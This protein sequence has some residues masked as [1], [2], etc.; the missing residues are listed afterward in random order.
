MNRLKERTLRELRDVET[1]SSLVSLILFLFIF[2]IMIFDAETTMKEGSEMEKEIYRVERKYGVRITGGSKLDKEI[3][4]IE[5]K[6]G[7]EL[8]VKEH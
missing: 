3:S 5:K 1:Q 2:G 8:K 4:E 6:Y 7:V